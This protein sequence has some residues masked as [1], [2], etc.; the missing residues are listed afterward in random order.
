MAGET[1]AKRERGGETGNDMTE[2]QEKK[3]DEVL[4]RSR[5]MD[6]VLFGMED[7]PG[8]VRDVQA[9]KTHADSMTLFK[10]KLLAVVATLSTFGSLLGAKL[11][12]FLKLG[13][14]Q[15]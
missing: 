8:L 1:E 13:G 6:F 5:K 11:A 4:D 9:L 10:A 14:S 15:N 2:D 12:A 3:L 7:R